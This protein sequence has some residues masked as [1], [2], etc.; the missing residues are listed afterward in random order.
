M[1]LCAVVAL[2]V[3]SWPTAPS[4]RGA[5]AASE[6]AREA[7]RAELGPRPPAAGWKLPR[8][9]VVVAAPLARGSTTA[10]L[11]AASTSETSELASAVAEQD[12][13]ATTAKSTQPGDPNAAAQAQGGPK[14][15][16]KSRADESPAG[17]NEEALATQPAPDGGQEGAGEPDDEPCSEEAGDED[18][19]DKDKDEDK[20]GNSED[21]PGKSKDAG[22][23]QDDEEEGSD[24]DDSP[25]KSG[26][27]AGKCKKNDGDDQGAPSSGGEEEDGSPSDTSDGEGAAEE[28]ETAPDDDTSEDAP[29]RS[30]EAPGHSGTGAGN[31]ENAGGHEREDRSGD[32]YPS[33]AQEQGDATAAG[34]AADERSRFSIGA[35][36]VV[37]GT[38]VPLAQAFSALQPERLKGQGDRRGIRK[39]TQKSRPAQQVQEQ[40]GI[41]KLERTIEQFTDTAVPEIEGQIDANDTLPKTGAELAS[42]I[43]AGLVLMALGLI[44]A[45]IKPASAAR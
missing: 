10:D 38:R 45:S 16:K 28:S 37:L 35:D 36:A 22:D 25:G 8:R 14:A 31:S 40:K 17:E 6:A 13:D 1:A 39:L 41:K 4:V 19:C 18:T 7:A 43:V 12:P 44:A 32:A 2:A 5:S 42:Y 21:A 29:G 26:D 3:T 11:E 33:S 34:H 15:G 30:G 20:P 23:S 9:D 27:A 24:S